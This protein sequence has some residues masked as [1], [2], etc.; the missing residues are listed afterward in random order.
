VVRL[1]VVAAVVLRTAVVV[2]TAT[3]V[4]LAVVGLA[5]YAAEATEAP[6]AAA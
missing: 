4:G 1:A 3:V 6:A 5:V 2:G